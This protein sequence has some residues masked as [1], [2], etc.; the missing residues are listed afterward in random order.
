[1]GASGSSYDA[2][3]FNHSNLKRRIENGTLG[4]TPP[5]PLGPGGSDLHYSLLGDDT[6]ALMPWLVKPYNRRQLTREE[7]IANYRISRGRR[8]V[9]NAFGILVSRF[10][11]LL[12]TMEQRPRVV[13]DIVLTCEA[14]QN[15]L[16]SHQG[17]QRDHQL[18]QT[19]YNHHRMTRGS[20]GK[21]KMSEIQEAKRQR[22]L[23]QDYFNNLAWGTGW[24]GQNLRRPRG[25][26]DAIINQSF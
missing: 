25:E 7:R 2:E 12:M 8:V 23:L 13:R 20:R 9:E 3:I 18:Q 4:L 14:L 6:F 11:V 17:E 10:R 24:A 1:M 19:T 21:I 15:M 22:N 26:E 5:E 16:R